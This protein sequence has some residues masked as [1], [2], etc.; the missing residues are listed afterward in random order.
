VVKNVQGVIMNQIETCTHTG[1]NYVKGRE[2]LKSIEKQPK[3]SLLA[4]EK[5]P[6]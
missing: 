6:S 4:L 1:Q 5:L 3:F 2:K